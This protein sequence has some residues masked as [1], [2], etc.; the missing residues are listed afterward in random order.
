MSRKNSSFKL[1]RLTRLLTAGV[2]LGFMLPLSAVSAAEDATEKATEKAEK[3]EN[4]DTTRYFRMED[5]L[6]TAERIPTNRWDTPANVT[7]I[8]AEEIEANHYQDIYE[9]LSHVNGVWFDYLGNAFINGC[10]QVVLMIDGQRIGTDVPQSLIGRGFDR[11]VSLRNV[12]SMKM[13]ERVE[14]LKGSAGTLYGADAIGGVIHVI[15]KTGSHEETT[16]DINAGSW[17]Q[18]K[19]EITNQGQYGN[20]SWFVATG[21]G[22]RNAVDF[23][24]GSAYPYASIVGS[25]GNYDRNLAVKLV[26][27]F[28]DSSSL[29]F[30][31]M[32]RND[33]DFHKGV[34]SSS[35][36]ESDMTH[37]NLHNNL[38]LT[39]NF[40]EKTST[41]GFLRIY[42]T[43]AQYYGTYSYYVPRSDGSLVLD[44]FHGDKYRMEYSNTR[45]GLSYQNG[46]ELG[47]VHK[48]IAGL[49]WYHDSA[50]S[51]VYYYDGVHATGEDTLTINTAAYVQDT[52]S[53][54]DKWTLIP[55]IRFEHYNKLGNYWSPQLA[56][57]YRADD[58]TKIYA[59]WGRVVRTP[60]SF[61]MH[62]S[63]PTMDSA[64]AY[65]GDTKVLGFEHEFDENTAISASAFDT[66]FGNVEREDY[67]DGREYR[68]D[69]KYR[70]IEVNFRQKLNNNFS[71][72]V[73]Y[74]HI[75][76][77]NDSTR[78]AQPNGYRLGLRYND[79]S[80][81][82]NLLGIMAS[83][84]DGDFGRAWDRFPSSYAIFDFNASYAVNDNFTVY[85]KV[86]NLTN[87][88]YAYGGSP[89][90]APGRSFL[91]GADCRF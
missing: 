57:N 62:A 46:W 11:S 86:N 87:R 81:K 78:I 71:Y 73:G 23:A 83:G 85:A 76:S 91:L 2:M 68:T 89:L 15:T 24:D 70:G 14:I 77:D 26:N 69:K 52:M 6:I 82:L 37:H 72:D 32:Y 31:A 67:G 7:V 38:S 49:D 74:S 84:F 19:A 60:M 90:H 20:L 58:K 88:D 25:E 5:W 54:T 8:T 27:R 43:E 48:L 42:N 79:G 41:P 18:R 17:G 33:S 59:S 40:K 55:G 13:I 66:K 65:T 44:I 61:K 10:G 56:V 35:M 21:F 34:V 22:K 47:K 12:P 45:Y 4:E 1:G 51:D 30:S 53:L 36:I 64:L 3:A 29:T 63:E 50:G 80:W 16:V 9:A 39:Y 75:S 28:D